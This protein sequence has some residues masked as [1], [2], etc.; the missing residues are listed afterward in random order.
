VLRA[1]RVG[2]STSVGADLAESLLASGGSDLMAD[3]FGEGPTDP[4]ATEAGMG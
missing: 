3:G 2:S 4:G 1:A